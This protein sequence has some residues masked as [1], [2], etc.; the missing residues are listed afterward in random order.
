MG[1]YFK[2]VNVDKKEYLLPSDFDY[3]SKSHESRHKGNAFLSALYELLAARWNGDRIVF[4]G[5][6]CEYP[7]D[8]QTLTIQKLSDQA[9]SED[10]LDYICENYRNVS[11]LFLAAEDASKEIIYDLQNIHDE[12]SFSCLKEY[13]IDLN[14]PMK[15]LFLKTGKRFRYTINHTKKVFYSPEETKTYYEDG[16]VCDY[17]DPLPVLMGF[18]RSVEPGLWLGDII[19]ISD[20]IIDGY[21]FLAQ[22]CYT[23]N[24]EITFCGNKKVSPMKITDYDW[25]EE[26][27]PHIL[28]RGKKYFEESRVSRIQRVRNTYLATVEGT[29]DYKVEIVLREDGID[30]M[31]CSCPYAENNNC[32][33]MAAVLFAME[34]SDPSIEEL[35]P[36]K[37][38]PIVSHVPM[39][40]SWLDAIDNMSD[41]V[42]RKELMK[43][44]DRDDR[45]K[46]RLAV[47]Y[48]GKLP[49]YQLQNWKADLQE[50]AGAYLDRT[51]RIDREDS[52][53]YLNDLG[54]FLDA[55]LPTL[56]EVDAVMDA[57][58]LVW[59]VMET[60][61]EWEIDDSYDELSGL[62]EDCKDDLKTLWSMS[63]ENQQEQMMQWYREH[64]NEEWPGGVK[65]MDRTF[66][67][68]MHSDVPIAGKRIVKY[69]GE[70]PC[71]LYDGEWISFP[72]HGHLYYDFVEE[73]AEYKEAEPI[74]EEIIKEKLGELYGEF[75]SCH[76]I[77]RLKKQLLMEKYGIEWY[78]PAEL[79]QY[80]I[81]D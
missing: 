55:K 49:E 73:T 10:Y 2:W 30:T 20:D 19:G 60:A 34:Q 58:H 8:T 54:N 61:L 15:G 45:L 18:G 32:K 72:K 52:W 57:F 4:L 74:I 53:E 6:E 9:K 12:M 43:L 1:E 65:H 68:L 48:L 41:S 80:T 69:V 79:N 5:D 75:G 39:E 35:P 36:A 40:I 78:S 44:A 62:F 21:T 50:L 11:C 17:L 28:A 16:S 27:A 56:L 37:L 26:F 59:I 13:G 22:L 51:G 64:R 46:E 42:I 77:W 29:E 31:L 71:F 33:H 25:R 66:H 38:P 47:L 3:G 24:N 7:L 81:F 76:N 67:L 23:D 63:A 14:D 70:E